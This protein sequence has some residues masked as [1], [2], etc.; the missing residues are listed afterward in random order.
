MLCGA[1]GFLLFPRQGYTSKSSDD[2]N[3][4]SEIIP[5]AAI[6]WFIDPDP[7]L[8]KTDNQGYRSDPSVPD[9][10]K[11]SRGFVRGVGT[12]PRKAAA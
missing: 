6:E 7:V 9:P 2:R 10:R 8:E 12:A 5:P 11:E 1:A 3:V 4:E